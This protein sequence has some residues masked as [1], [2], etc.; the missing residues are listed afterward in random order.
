MA[1]SPSV[2]QVFID[3]SERQGEGASTFCDLVS[4]HIVA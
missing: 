4:D 3:C 1:R 2:T